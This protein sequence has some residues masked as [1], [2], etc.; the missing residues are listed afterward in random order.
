MRSTTTARRTTSSV[1]SSTRHG[2]SQLLLEV[3]SIDSDIEALVSALC[4][5]HG[6]SASA[7]SEELVR[8]LSSSALV[9]GL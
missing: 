3:G 7:A 6:L 2:W 4:K 5:Q 1:S 8:R 9:G